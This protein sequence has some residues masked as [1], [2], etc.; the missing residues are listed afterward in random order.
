MYGYISWPGVYSFKEELGM[1]MEYL[2]EQIDEVMK[3]IEETED[4]VAKQSSQSITDDYGCVKPVKHFTGFLLSG[5]RKTPA[6]LREK[7]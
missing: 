2:R 5:F 6:N 3:K 1:F 7:E 4:L